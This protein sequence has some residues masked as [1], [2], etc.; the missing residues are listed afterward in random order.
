[1]V[2]PW[3]VARACVFLAEPLNSVTG[4]T[5]LMDGGSAAAGCYV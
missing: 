5:M 2:Q 3:E 1:M 4:I